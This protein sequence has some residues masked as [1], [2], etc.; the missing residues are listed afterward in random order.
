MRLTV[1]LA[2]SL[3]GLAAADYVFTASYGTTD[4][5]GTDLLTQGSNLGERQ[6]GCAAWCHG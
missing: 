5:T 1:A 2:A 6:R 4:C 3:A